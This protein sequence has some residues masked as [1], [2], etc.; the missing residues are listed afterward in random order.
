MISNAK[1]NLPIFC[2]I[3][4]I[5]LLAQAQTKLKIEEFKYEGNVI[6]PACISLLAIQSDG[7]N[8]I[9][10][11]NLDKVKLRG[12]VNSNYAAEQV[13][14]EENGNRVS[15][16][17]TKDSTGGQKINVSYQ[18]LKAL[19]KGKYIVKY[20]ESSEEGS[21]DSSEEIMILKI[22][23]FKTLDV[24]SKEVKLQET[25]GL[26]KIGTIDNIDLA[27]KNEVMM[28]IKEVN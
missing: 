7:D 10:R 12:C 25:Q 28:K 13:K 21:L 20:S 17:I 14:V 1:Y 5:N 19:G 3:F 4:L 26:I 11:I 18:L 27:E 16:V 6:H 9:S 24:T 23:P 8:L 15:S 22:A 2:T